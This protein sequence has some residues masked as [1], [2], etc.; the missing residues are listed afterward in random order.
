[1]ERLTSASNLNCHPPLT[2]TPDGNKKISSYI[3]PKMMLK[4]A[5]IIPIA[6]GVLMTASLPMVEASSREQRECMGNCLG[7]TP[8]GVFQLIMCTIFCAFVK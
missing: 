1:M 8:S 4:V 2:S 6:M 7:P 5:Q 3:S